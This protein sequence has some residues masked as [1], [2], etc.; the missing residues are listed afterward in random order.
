MKDDITMPDSSSLPP[1]GA[2]EKVGKDEDESLTSCGFGSWRPA[3]LQR[4]ATPVWF[5]VSMSLVGVIQSTTGPLFFAGISTLEKRYA[6]DSKVSAIILIADNFSEMLLSPVV[7]YL[8]VRYNRARLI[9]FGELFLAAGCFVCAAPYFIYGPA[10]HFLDS[11]IT[12]GSMFGNLT[13]SSGMQMCQ[14]F[15]GTGSSLLGTADDPACSNGRGNTVWPAENFLVCGSFFR[16]I[17]IPC[18]FVIGIP[19]LDD[20]VSKKHSPL[21]MGISQSVRLMGPAAGFMLC[22]FCLRFFE[23]PFCKY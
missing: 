8:A 3:H 20:N 5:L 15:N 22:S 4:F 16:G 14:A 13:G 12:S 17:G 9:A 18:Y 6:F 23:D 7:G 1:E 10:L 21:F 11:D 2:K 19:Y